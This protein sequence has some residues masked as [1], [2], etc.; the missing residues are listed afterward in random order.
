MMWTS[1]SGFPVIQLYKHTKQKALPTSLQSI[2]INKPSKLANIDVRKQLNA[3]AP[4][5]IHS[6]DSIHMLMTCISA[7]KNNIP[8]VSVHDSFWTLPCDV[9]KLSRIIREEFV[10][11]HSSNIIENLRE[12]MMYTTRKSFQLVYVKNK[13]N[14]ELIEELNRLRSQYFE[15]PLKFTKSITIRYF[16]TSWFFKRIIR[17]MPIRLY[18]W[19]GNITHIY[20]S[21]QKVV[22]SC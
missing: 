8:F 12:D 20:T 1:M 2:I 21:G 5:F 4:N 11:L 15:E 14:L 9:N 3:V 6:I 16:I 18:N 7:E 19:L 17:M 22:Q 13:D 10:R